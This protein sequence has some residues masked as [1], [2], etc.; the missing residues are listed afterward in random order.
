[1]SLADEL[2]NNLTDEEIAAYTTEDAEQNH[3]VIGADRFI[4]VPSEL[5]RIAVQHDENVEVVTFD[6]PRYWKNLDM[7]KM[8]IYIN[9]MLPSGKLGCYCANNV[10]IDELDTNIM[11]FDWNITSNA[12][13]EKGTLSFL[14]CIKKKDVGGKT[15]NHWNS[16]LNREMYVSAGLECEEAII[17]Q[18]PDIIT[19]ILERID[20]EVIIANNPAVDKSLT[21]EGF[22]ADAKATGRAISVERARIDALQ[23]I[24]E[25]ST[26][27]DA[28]LYDINIGYDGTDW[29]APGAAV[30]GQAVQLANYIDNKTSQLSDEKIDKANGVG[31]G[32]FAPIIQKDIG[33]YDKLTLAV[34]TYACSIDGHNNV[35]EHT[36]SGGG[37]GHFEI[38]VNAGEIYKLTID[39]PPSSSVYGVLFA[40]EKGVLIKSDI[41][42]TS[43]ITRYTDYE[44]TTPQ[45]ATKLF[46]SF[47]QGSAYAR[48][49]YRLNYSPI[50]TQN[51]VNN[52]IDNGL[53]SFPI[54][55]FYKSHITSKI[56]EIKELENAY[57]SKGET[58][59]FITDIHYPDNKMYSFSLLKALLENTNISYV[60]CGGDSIRNNDDLSIGKSYMYEFMKIAKNAIGDKFVTI[61]GNHD[62]NSNSADIISVDEVYSVF[63]KN[64]ERIVVPDTN[65]LNGFYWYLD[66][67][68][69][70]I[71]YVGLNTFEDTNEGILSVS[72]MKWLCETALVFPSNDW[73]VAFFSHRC[74]S[75]YRTSLMV[76]VREI[77]KCLR[78][79][80]T[81][82]ATYTDYNGE[83]YNIDVDFTN[84]NTSVLFVANGHDHYDTLQ[85][86][87]DIA[88]FG[89]MSDAQYRDNDSV[90]ERAGINT[91]AIDIITINK[92]TNTINLTRVG[93]GDNRSFTYI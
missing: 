39:T 27:A 37:N 20:G 49:I 8:K 51:F 54:P 35:V 1:M 17:A 76:E 33:N 68:I 85:T 78:Y 66:N 3:I 87:N 44:I 14:V 41:P 2:L 64:Q 28:A 38:E 36:S 55:D 73:S 59:A 30:R 56:F 91:Q 72:Q 15:K 79:R 9:Y 75:P 11:H 65:K 57:G 26:S 46:V 86:D 12:T 45:G 71:R 70:K 88:Y 47:R 61:Y 16:E 83:T 19:Q 77:I 50:A 5:K 89:T 32:Q 18:Y 25:G 80:G 22:A 13:P 67:P 21:I 24:P 90:P 74:F 84:T 62:N 69:Q 58:I 42:C 7:S 82:T 34:K 6:C 52:I 23:A 43:E 29:Q 10:V 93:A 48:N 31:M 60:I 4:T 63:A 40:D 92:K 53:N 81:Y